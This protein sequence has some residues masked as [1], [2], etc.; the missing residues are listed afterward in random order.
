M[1]DWV[2]CSDRM[3]EYGRVVVFYCFEHDGE[4]YSEVGTLKHS[5]FDGGGDAFVENGYF[6][7]SG[8]PVESCEAW[9]YVTP[10]ESKLHERN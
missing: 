10:M 3:P 6:D 9:A 8:L 4:F 5:F 1:I 2:L 7:R